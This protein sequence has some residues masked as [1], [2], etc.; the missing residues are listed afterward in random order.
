MESVIKI[1]SKRPRGRRR[2]TLF[3]WIVLAWLI[4]QVL[5]LYVPLLWGSLASFKDLA[6]YYG[7]KLG[8]PGT[9][10]LSNYAYILNNFSV[11]VFTADGVR[12][13]YFEGMLANTILLGVGCTVANLFCSVLFAYI[14]FRYKHFRATKIIKTII[15]V[16]MAIP[17][18]TMASEIAFF[19]RI[20]LYDNIF[21][22]IFFAGNPVNLS[23]F[24][25]ISC[26]N[27]VP[28]DLIDAAEIDGISRIG[29]MFK[30]MIPSAKALIGLF[31][32]TSLISY[33]NDYLIALF[34]L[35]TKPTM[36]YGLFYLNLSSNL[37]DYVP[38]KLA[39]ALLLSAPLIV[40]FA[41]LGERMMG[42][43]SLAE[44]LKG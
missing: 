17:L 44:G 8:F 39:A 41:A 30:I 28:R 40:V 9:W 14:M 16:T 3:G 37:A 13:V 25:F 35:P 6:D 7:N 20:G 1:K 43:M 34:Y 21:A 22:L 33:W 10:T 18:G 42:S 31:F 29:L 23:M 26:L 4:I 27:A 19:K 38:Y 11:Q 15:I 5:I 32:L 2:L 24:I 36:G 12:S